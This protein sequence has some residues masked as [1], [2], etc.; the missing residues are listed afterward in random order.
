MNDDRDDRASSARQ[1]PN[2]NSSVITPLKC[3][4]V[5]QIDEMAGSM[6]IDDCLIFHIFELTS[7]R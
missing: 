5:S 1:S 3:V 4:I 2:R 6:Y 7:F